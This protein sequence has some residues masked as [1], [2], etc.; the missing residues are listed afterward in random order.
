MNAGYVY[1]KDQV[2]LF[3]HEGDLV[4]EVAG[5]DLSYKTMG[6]LHEHSLCENFRGEYLRETYDD[7]PGILEP[8]AIDERDIRMLCED[9]TEIAAGRIDRF[10]RTAPEQ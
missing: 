6:W 7:I 3:L 4:S 5:V 2:C 8:Y 1:Y 9:I 10:L